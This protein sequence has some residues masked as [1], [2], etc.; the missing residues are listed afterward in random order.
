MCVHVR[1]CVPVIYSNLQ[2]RHLETDVIE[3]TFTF[4]PII[5]VKKEGKHICVV[6]PSAFHRYVCT[7]GE[8]HLF[9][10]KFSLLSGKKSQRSL[11][12]QI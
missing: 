6:F 4:R 9:S 8:F 11:K 2:W 3:F 10:M 12:K 5:N 7:A 1:A